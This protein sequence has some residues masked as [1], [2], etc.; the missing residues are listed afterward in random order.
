MTTRRHFQLSALACSMFCAQKPR[1]VTADQSKFLDLTPHLPAVAGDLEVVF[2][3]L[4]LKT[5]RAASVNAMLLDQRHPPWSSFKIPNLIIA[6]ETGA[7]LDLDHARRWDRQRRPAAPFWPAAW[8]RD[9]TLRSA[10]RQSVPWYFQDVAIQ[11]GADHY[12]ASLAGFGYGNADI[13]SGEDRFWL[14]GSLRI[15]VSEQVQF[16]EGV[17]DG[18]LGISKRSSTLLREAALI[19]S[20]L[21]HSLF[22]KTGAGALE[23]GNPEGPFEGWLVG[24]SERRRRPQ[25]VFALYVRGPSYDAIRTARLDLAEALLI[26]SAHLPVSWT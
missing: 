18:S 3:A 23:A 21:D 17:L 1:K 11:V 26:A 7:A 6:L 4:D 2:H 19:K 13:S 9:Q 14:G 16:L 22:G 20:D 24:W 25:A 8:R 12:R 10:F 5:G 15:S